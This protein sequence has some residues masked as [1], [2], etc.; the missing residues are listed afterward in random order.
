MKTCTKCK[1][2]K[3]L[4]EFNKQ[5][6]S[7]DGHRWW[8][9]VCDGADARQRRLNPEHQRRKRENSFKFSYGITIDDYE[10]MFEAQ[11]GLCAI[12]KQPETKTHSR[13]KQ[14]LPLSVDHC[15]DSKKVRGLLC[16][17]CNLMLGLANDDIGKL[18]SAILYLSGG[19]LNE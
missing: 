10:K 4:D 11:A 13:S 19:D 5:A 9:R 15:H 14:L 17:Q 16:S 12:C 1:E 18:T 6:A 8:C 2:V 3:P 7:N